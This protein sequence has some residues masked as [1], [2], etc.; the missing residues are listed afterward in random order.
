MRRREP[1]RRSA[2]G[3]TSLLRRPT[4]RPALRHVKRKNDWARRSAL[5]R[6]C[7]LLFCDAHPLCSLRHKSLPLFGAEQLAARLADIVRDRVALAHRLLLFPMRLYLLVR[8][9]DIYDLLLIFERLCIRTSL[10]S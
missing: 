2:L 5:R 7:A 8:A 6:L 9:L 3:S 4:P 1:P 10:T